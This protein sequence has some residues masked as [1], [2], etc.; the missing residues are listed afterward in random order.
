VA[1]A[2]RQTGISRKTGFKF[3]R[4]FRQ[5]GRSGLDDLSRRPRRSPRETSPRW[6]KAILKLRGQYPHWGSKKIHHYLRRLHPYQR[7]PRP[8]T[9]QR[10]L[11][12]L[13][14]SI[15][16][17]R[18]APRGP[19]I[20]RKELTPA[21]HPNHV[22]TLDFKG[23][24][25]TADGV[26]QEPLTV[27]DLF[28]RYGLC[29]RL[30]S[31]QEDRA[32]RQVL[33]RLFQLQGLPEI[34]RVDNGSPFSGKGALGLS[35]L[36]VWWR[37][38]GIRV[39]LTRPARPGDNAAHEQFHGCYQREVIAQGKSADRR[40]LQRRS[41]RWLLCYN[42][43]RPNEALSGKTPSQLYRP[44]SR[45]YAGEPPALTYPPGWTKRKVRN[46]GNIKWQGRLRHIGRA[47]VAQ[48]IGLKPIKKK[49]AAWQVYLDKDLIGQ[50]YDQ[51]LTGL[52]PAI[53]KL[54]ARKKESPMSWR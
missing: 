54:T 22:W 47:F 42:E 34:I 21:R 52:R 5:A 2:C 17:K 14:Q 3:L 11:G 53:R 1:R 37:R 15:K 20:P 6:R 13:G 23:W 40:Q 32:V 48:T 43:Q 51:D 46:R 31:N 50:L 12:L 36:S 10:W 16:R 24:I 41:N 35:R 7:P 44:S 27:R 8:R 45:K 26:R 30:L 18:K 29:I 39:Q 4:R 33:Q 25:R 9:I 19:V 38:L 28:S 49:S